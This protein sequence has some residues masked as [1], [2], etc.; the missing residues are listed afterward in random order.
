MCVAENHPVFEGLGGFHEALLTWYAGVARDLPWRLTR[1]PYAIWVSEIMCQQTQVATVVP[2]FER[3]MGAFPTATALADASLDEVLSHW[4]GL[5]YYRRARLMHAAA[6]VLAT[7][8]PEDREGWLAV[9]GVGRYTAGAVA[10]IAFDEAVAVVDGNVDRVLSRLF[11]IGPEASDTVRERR[12]WK[13]AE[14]LVPAARPGDYN[15]ALMELGATVCTPRRPACSECPLVGFCAAYEQGAQLDFPPP[16]RRAKVRDETT[17]LL[18]IQ[19]DGR[20]AMVQRPAE[21][22]HGGLWEFPTG[23]ANVDL[24]SLKQCG[25]SASSVAGL[26]EFVHVFSHIRMTYRLFDVQGQITGVEWVEDPRSLAIS[27]AM[28]KALGL[29]GLE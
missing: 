25:I 18:V 23:P 6:Q 26:G 16:K 11:A 15:Q 13:V 1:D 27:T 20:F 4:A 14:E 12:V 17:N 10:S 2:Y 22:L 3:W 29:V 7:G 5:G 8:I 21:G 28:R 9:P 19:R 24:G